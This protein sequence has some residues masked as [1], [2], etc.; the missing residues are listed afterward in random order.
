MRS[1]SGL[2]IT[3]GALAPARGCS[4]GDP[5]AHVVARRRTADGREVEIHDDGAVT[6]YYGVAI[7][8][9]PVARPRG[10]EAIER[11]RAA[12]WL[13]ADELCLYAYEE[14]PALHAAAR[15]VARRGGGPGDLRAAV[16]EASAPRVPIRWEVLATDNRGDVTC[17]FGV[18]PRLRWGGVG[19]W[20][21]H[22]VYEVMHRVHGDHGEGAWETSGFRF[23]SQRDLFRHLAGV[24][25][26]K[27]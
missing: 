2:E 19:V 18:L 22:G 11:E 25:N 4:C 17:R 12:A 13:F 15:R 26:A 16:A 20:H 5:K 6:G 21:E 8:G 27:G 23:T 7:P 1:V 14:L 3:L 10:I 24:G 9:V